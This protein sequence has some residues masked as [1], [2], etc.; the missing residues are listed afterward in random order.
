MRDVLQQPASNSSKTLD[1]YNP[2]ASDSPLPQ[3]HGSYVGR[4][5][6]AL[7]LGFITVLLMAVVYVVTRSWVLLLLAL[8]WLIFLRLRERT[9]VIQLTNEKITV[10]TL[11]SATTVE[12]QLVIGSRR[13]GNN[14]YISRKSGRAIRISLLDFKRD[15]IRNLIQTLD[16]CIATYSNQPPRESDATASQSDG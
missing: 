16:W 14:L 5:N 10:E 13:N 3:V 7:G 6:L 1:Y 8:L 2:F 4:S 15:D 11:W 12:W 9:P